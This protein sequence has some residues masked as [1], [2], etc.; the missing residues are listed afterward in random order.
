MTRKQLLIL[1]YDINFFFNLI[2]FS[3][4]ITYFNKFQLNLIKLCYQLLSLFLT[5][6]LI[7]FNLKFYL[8][9]TI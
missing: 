7:K 5:F 3:I 2:E 4:S 6:N 1:N 9:K 8:N